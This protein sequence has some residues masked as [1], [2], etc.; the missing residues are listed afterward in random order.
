MLFKNV[1][2][3]SI[4]PTRKQPSPSCVLKLI[5]KKNTAPLKVGRVS[6]NL[7]WLRD[8][9]LAH[10]TTLLTTVWLDWFID[11]F[12]LKSAYRKLKMD[13]LVK[14]FAQNRKVAFC[15]TGAAVA[16]LGLALGYKY[17]RRQKKLT[18]VG[19]VSQLL[20]HPMKSG[21]AVFVPTAEC[22][23][24]GLKCGDLRDRWDLWQEFAGITTKCR[25]S[26]ITNAK[27]VV[28]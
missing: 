28:V 22:L 20:L 25:A 23:R 27:D 26:A 8:V 5:K 4:W 13:F 1:L 15:M 12:F 2:H 10:T 21:K 6:E 7:H 18:R 19:V 17:T 11:L 14:L 9:P 16:L 3:T 24:M